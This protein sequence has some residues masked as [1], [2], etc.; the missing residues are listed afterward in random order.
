[1]V[2][3]SCR[4]HEPRAMEASHKAVGS[5][6]LAALYNLALTARQAEDVSQQSTTAL[7]SAVACI[8]CPEKGKCSCASVPGICQP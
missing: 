5:L 4:Q 1:M 6:G 2:G 8:L 7:A 3:Q